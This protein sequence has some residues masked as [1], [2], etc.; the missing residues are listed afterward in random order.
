MDGSIFPWNPFLWVYL[1]MWVWI[2]GVII[3][4]Q[5]IDPPGCRPD[6]LEEVPIAFGILMV[7]AIWPIMWLTYPD[8][9]YRAYN[10]AYC[11]AVGIP[12]N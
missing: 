1:A 10:N 2:A 11:I 8:M 12:N 7:T 3:Y 5:L 6:F 9:F 4:S